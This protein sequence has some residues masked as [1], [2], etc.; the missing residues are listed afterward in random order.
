VS[1]GSRR[2]RRREMQMCWESRVL[3]KRQVVWTVWM[4]RVRIMRLVYECCLWV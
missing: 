2:I 1:W 4:K 3:M